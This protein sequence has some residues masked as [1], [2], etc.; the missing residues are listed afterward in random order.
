[1]NHGSAAARRG[2]RSSWR[3]LAYAAAGLAAA[4]ALVAGPGCGDAD[5]A[6]G[7]DDSGVD[8]RITALANP[9]AY[10]PSQCYTQ[11]EGTA[12]RVHNPCYACHVASREPNYLDDGDVQLA[13]DL[14]GDEGQTVVNPWTNLFQDRRQAVAAVPDAEIQ[15]YVGEDNYAAG[16]RLVLAERLRTAL[17]RTWDVDGD[18]RWGGYLPDAGLR[19]DDQGY[20]LASDGRRSGWRAFGYAPFLGTFW[21]TNGATDDVLI[22]LPAAFR[23][24]DSGT[25]DAGIYATNLAILS[26]LIL[27]RDV[28]LEAVVDERALQVDLDGDGTLGTAATVRYDWAPLQGRTMSWVG[29]ARLEQIAGRVHLAAGL[30]P[31]G[32]EFLHSVRYLGTAGAVVD[33]APRLKELRYAR[34]HAW[35]TYSDLQEMARQEVREKVVNPERTRQFTGNA[36]LGLGNGQGWTYQ[37]FIEDAA[38]RLRPQTYEETAFCIGCHSGI[39]AT[40]DSAFAFPRRFVGATVF[41]QGWYHWSQKGLAGTP[42][43]LRSDGRHEYSL[44]LTLNGAGDEFRGNEEVAARFFGSDGQPDAQALQRLHADVATL[45]LPSRERALRLNK[46]Y[47]LIVREQG[48]VRGRDPSVAPVSTV[49]RELRNGLPTGVTQAET[50][51]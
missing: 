31:E 35:Y 17:P 36:E 10:I 38:G 2:K 3:G 16:G 15:A 45:L 32:T 33:M 4:A 8:L 19:F 7:A 41:R 29:Q 21:P 5:G 25:E 37:G 18:G 23:S 1:M 39:G 12:G 49:H 14:P 24:N 26:A 46:A 40:T 48:F 13:Y 44:Y 20:D 9:T 43:P 30:F 27:R 51:P 28:P 22:R 6:A 42:E 34:K 50:G 47:R 11:T